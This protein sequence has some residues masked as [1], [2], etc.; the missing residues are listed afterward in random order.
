MYTALIKRF[1]FNKFYRVSTDD[2]SAL[3]LK[4]VQVMNVPAKVLV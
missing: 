4:G 2:Y 1:R 3:A